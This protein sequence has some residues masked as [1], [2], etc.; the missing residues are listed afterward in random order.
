MLVGKVVL[1]GVLINF[2]T[3]LL[4]VL[5]KL[6]DVFDVDESQILMADVVFNFTN[7]MNFKLVVSD[8]ILILLVCHC[9]H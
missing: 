5:H 1:N 7:L 8:A 9:H 2:V 6:G 3:E 4:L